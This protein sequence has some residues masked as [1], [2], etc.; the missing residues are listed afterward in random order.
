MEEYIVKRK[1]VNEFIHIL[2]RHRKGMRIYMDVNRKD[3]YTPP[4]QFRYYSIIVIKDCRKI[5]GLINKGYFLHR[6]W[7]GYND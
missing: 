5:Q 6:K 7:V 2:R 4:T 3:G 1:F